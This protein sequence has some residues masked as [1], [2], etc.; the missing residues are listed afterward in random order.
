TGG[1]GASRLAQSA[2]ERRRLL[3]FICSNYTISEGTLTV[4]MRSPFETLAKAAE[5][6]DLAGSTGRVSNRCDRHQPSSV[7]NLH[8]LAEA[9]WQCRMSG[10]EVA[11]ASTF[12]ARRSP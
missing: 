8:T 7:R 11:M 12:A 10:D 5:S 3:Q 9:T 1:G 2:E 4:S 6:G